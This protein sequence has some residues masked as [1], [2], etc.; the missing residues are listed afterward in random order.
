MKVNQKPEYKISSCTPT[1]FEIP[2]QKNTEK[3]ISVRKNIPVKRNPNP[4]HEK[5]AKNSHPDRGR[6]GHTSACEN[7]AIR[8]KEP[9][10]NPD[11]DRIMSKGVLMQYKKTLKQNSS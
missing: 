7:N 2:L 6:G 5:E 3:Y 9:P 4:D 10:N 1:S 11:Q 8:Q